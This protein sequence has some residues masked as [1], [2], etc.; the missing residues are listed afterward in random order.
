MPGLGVRHHRNFALGVDSGSLPPSPRGPNAEKEVQF[1]PDG[2]YLATVAVSPSL[3]QFITLWR[4]GH[5]GRPVRVLVRPSTD[6]STPPVAISHADRLVAVGGSDGSITVYDLRD[7][8]GRGRVFSGRHNGGVNGLAFG[9]DD[10]TL[11][12]GG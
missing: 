4:S 8:N 10:R 5:Y 6:G 9:P 7:P 2:R 12:S 11:V 3:T 1:S